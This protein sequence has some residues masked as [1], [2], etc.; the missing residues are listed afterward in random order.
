MKFLE[1]RRNEVVQLFRAHLKK[2]VLAIESNYP[3][4]VEML[5][6]LWGGLEQDK[7]DFREYYS[8]LTINTRGN[9]AGFKPEALLEL[10]AIK[11]LHDD[12]FGAEEPADV[13]SR[14]VS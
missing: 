7:I 12:T 11:Q 13:W 3:H 6:L 9:R 2:D 5:V 10:V 14:V 4:V 1:K 8:G